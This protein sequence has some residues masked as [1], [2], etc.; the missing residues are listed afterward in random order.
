MKKSFFIGMRTFKTALCVLACLTVYEAFSFVGGFFEGGSIYS[1]L[2]AAI[3]DGSP[4]FACI[5]AVICMQESLE[6]SKKVALSRV[7]G[8]VVGGGSAVIL[9]SVSRKILSGRLYILFAVIGVILIISLCNYL[10]NP[11]SVS[12]SVIT[13]LIIFVGTDVSAPLYFAVNRVAGTLIGAFSAL[14]INRF[15]APPRE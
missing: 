7:I 14:F 9:L 5:A 10:N 3:F 12:I 1:F 6:R 11:I 15:I 2:K 4:S 8:S 13:F